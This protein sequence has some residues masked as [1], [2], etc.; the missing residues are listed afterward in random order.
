[1]KKPK[2]QPVDDEEDVYDDFEIVRAIV[3]LARNYPRVNAKRLRELVV[4]NYPLLGNNQLA[5]CTKMITD[6]WGDRTN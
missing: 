3:N 4:E 6:S 1:M 5:R 2:A